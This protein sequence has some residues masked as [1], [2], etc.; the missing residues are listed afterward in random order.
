ME[1]Y[2]IL[3][4][5]D[6]P[7]VVEIMAKKIRE[8]GYV[9]LTAGD[10]EDAWEKIQKES[11]DIILLDLNMPKLDG[12]DVLKKMREHSPGQ[13]WQPVII[14][15][16]RNKLEDMQKGFALEADHYL[17]KPCEIS[18]ILKAITLMVNLIP[19]RKSKLEVESPE[20]SNPINK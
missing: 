16:A 15:S 6:E 4:A 3:I 19:Q 13:K 17:T 10:G 5:D 1:S 2:K 20:N 11:P 12:F 14:I 7:E 8:K 9:V 18:D